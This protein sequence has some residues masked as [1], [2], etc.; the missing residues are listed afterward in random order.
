MR[1]PHNKSKY[2]LFELSL[3]KVDN[4][5]FSLLVFN[6]FLFEMI[7][8]TKV[9]LLHEEISGSIKVYAEINIK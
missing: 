2:F 3:S 9:N 5:G 1:F 4:S 6:K 7:Q 8:A